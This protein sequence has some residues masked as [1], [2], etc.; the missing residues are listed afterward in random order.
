MRGAIYRSKGERRRHPTLGLGIMGM[1]EDRRVHLHRGIGGASENAASCP[2]GGMIRL[3]TL[4]HILGDALDGEAT[5][6][7]TR[8]G[9]A[10]PIGDHRHEGEALGRGPVGLGGK[11]GEVDLDLAPERRDEEVILV[12]L[13]RLSH[14]GQAEY[15]EFLVSGTATI[16]VGI[17]V[18]WVSS[19]K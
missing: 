7:F 5:G 10:D 9:A 3:D 4:G 19:Y 18:G 16:S 1:L 8:L 17:S 14:M 11:A 6:L 12:R 13:P 15:V 2:L